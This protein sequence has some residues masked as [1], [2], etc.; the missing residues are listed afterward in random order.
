MRESQ[1]RFTKKRGTIG[2]LQP[3]LPERS[4]EVTPRERIL[5]NLKRTTVLEQH[6]LVGVTHNHATFSGILC[7]E[8][9]VGDACRPIEGRTALPWIQSDTTEKPDW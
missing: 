6:L 4:G 5:L 2:R 1:G 8:V 3:E 9:P 7:I